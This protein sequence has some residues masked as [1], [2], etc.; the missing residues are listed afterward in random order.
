MNWFGEDLATAT[1]PLQLALA[2]FIGLCLG[3]FYT[4]LA[5]R[6]LY[7]C[8]GPGRKVPQRWRIILTRPSFC[9]A[10]ERPI[11]GLELWPILGYLITRGRCAGCGEKIGLLTLAGEAWLAV[12]I[13]IALWSGASWPLAIFSALFLGHLY[14]ALAVDWNYLQLD[15][16]N[17]LFLFLWAA[18]A[19]FEASGRNGALF[20]D[21]VYLGLGAAAVFGALFLVSLL[22][23]QGLGFGDVILA[24]I[25]GLFLDFWPLFFVIQAAALLS[26][27]HLAYVARD[28]RAPAPLGA[29]LA[30]ATLIGAP[31]FAA[32]RRLYPELY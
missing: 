15:H 7:F 16:E 6:I 3:S 8:Y 13:P 19:S 23:R 25:L 11:R 12:C 22:R 26:L 5:A 18:A 17:A 30:L 21:Q 10:C 27:L 4:A 14:T 31:F 1:A 24:G 20:L 29:Y 32:L 28:W 2:A 9:F